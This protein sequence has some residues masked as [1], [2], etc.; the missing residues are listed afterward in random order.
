MKLRILKEEA[1][2]GA[3]NKKILG[4]LQKAFPDG[5][6]NFK[7]SRYWHGSVPAWT[8]LLEEENSIIAHV[9]IVERS[10]TAGK[11][12][13]RIAGLQNVCVA[14]EHRG[15]NLSNMVV[16]A[17]MDEAMRLNIDFGLLF[18]IKQIEKIYACGGWKTL[19]ERTVVRVEADGREISIPEKNI[20]MYYPLVKKNFPEGNIHLQGNDW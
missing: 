5:V 9:G 13:I 7:E 16:K 1:I 3:L 4:C 11:E 6:L 8:V 14:P 19:H 15:K 17:S 10:I 2:D 18:C 20:V 12:T